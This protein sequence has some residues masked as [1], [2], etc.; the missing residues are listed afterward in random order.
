M[1]WGR[2]QLFIPRHRSTI[3]PAVSWGEE[4]STQGPEIRMLVLELDGWWWMDGL[5][6]DG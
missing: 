1:W 3:S 4:H 5:W 2:G 6:M